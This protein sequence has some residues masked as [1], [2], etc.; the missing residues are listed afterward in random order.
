MIP[1]R[2]RTSGSHKALNHW[3]LVWFTLLEHDWVSLAIVPAEGRA[4]AISVARALTDIGNSYEEH[5]VQ[6]IEAEHLPVPIAR[7][8]IATMTHRAES[9]SRTIIAVSSPIVDYNAIPIARAADAS[10]LLV[11]LGATE[12]AEAKRVLG[13][14]GRDCFI[15]SITSEP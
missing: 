15:G 2:A 7:Q 5:S 4:S 11:P 3:A 13:M 8:V 6:L 9:G 1:A 14:I 10:I 12:V